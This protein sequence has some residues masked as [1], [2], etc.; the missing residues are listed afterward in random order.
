MSLI[1]L[2]HC[3]RRGG[4]STYQQQQQSDQ[5][6]KRTW[7]SRK[8]V[9]IATIVIVALLITTAWILS[10]LN[11]IPATW[12]TIITAVLTVATAVFTLVAAFPSLFGFEKPEQHTTSSSTSQVQHIPDSLSSP[13]PV[14]QRGIAGLPPPTNPRTIQPRAKEVQEIYAQLTQDDTT[15][16]VLTGIGGAGKSTLAALVSQHEEE[17]RIDG[18]GPFAA[19]AL[20]LRVDAAAEIGMTDLMGNLMEALGKAMPDMSSLTPANQAAALFNALNTTEKARLV[21]LDQFETLLD[22]QSGHARADR[23]GVGELIDAFNSQPCRCRV[24]LTSRLWPTGTHEYPPA[25]MQEYA[26]KGL[27]SAEGI[28]LLRKQGVVGTDDELRSAVNRCDGHALSLTLLASLLRSDRSLNL[29][30]LLT[31]PLYARLWTGGTGKIAQNQLDYIYTRQLNEVQR[32][33]LHAFSV[34]RE[35]VPL[36]AVEPL[37]RVKARL[38]EDQLLAARDVLLSQHLLQAMGA[39]RYQLHAIVASYA[40]DHFD[41]QSKEANQAALR[42]AHAKAAQYYIQQA[43]TDCLPRK[44]RRKVSDAQPLIEATWHYAQAGQWQEAY[45]LM[46][47]E[48][49]F[50][51]LRLWRGNAVLLELDRLLLPPEKWHAKPEQAASLYNNLGQVYDVLGKKQEA[52][53]YFE[54]ALAIR[55]EVGDR[56]GE[57]ATLWN[58]GALYFRQDRNDAGLA[59]F[60]LARDIYQEVLSPY[61]EGVQRWIERLRKKASEEEFAALLAK[62]EPQASLI[63]EQALREGL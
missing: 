27:E 46:N 30:A 52:L 23:P 60:L 55:R 17:Q 26:V 22:S 1:K 47:K 51:D 39:L 16:V 6:K 61:R 48:G 54:Q 10:I 49:L 31:D 34:Y 21:I 29:Q 45:D 58:I 2:H 14:V 35:P 25:S 43:A 57:G 63:V 59:C 50:A 42:I 38:S 41:E 15:A 9:V 44:E 12:A 18:K 53:R 19:E 4:M 56:R 3:I 24:L 7:F 62:I 20:W 13:D 5:E 11:V 36:A 8:N 32:Q 37:L 33:L 40:R 28:E